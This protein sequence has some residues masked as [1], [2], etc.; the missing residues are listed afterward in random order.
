MPSHTIIVVFRT[1]TGQY[2][3]TYTLVVRMHKGHALAH[4]HS[5]FMYRVCAPAHT[6]VC[7]LV[8]PQAPHKHY[9]G[10]YCID[11]AAYALV[12]NY[13]ACNDRARALITLALCAGWGSIPLHT[14][15]LCV[16]SGH[17][18][19]V[20][21]HR[22]VV[23][24]LVGQY[25]LVHIGVMCINWV[26]C[27]IPSHALMLCALVGQH[28]LTQGGMPSRTLMVRVVCLDRATRP[29]VHSCY[30]QRRVSYPRTH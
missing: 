24:S 25:A 1:L 17:Y 8:G 18:A 9:C 15:M 20:N 14:L 26:V 12:H 5:V 10:V 19:L 22:S 3:L 30:V 7:A 28:A 4:T 13:V 27:I 2:A 11:R 21:V 23:R 29:C 6:H 16:S